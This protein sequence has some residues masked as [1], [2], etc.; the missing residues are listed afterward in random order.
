[1]TSNHN[2]KTTDSAIPMAHPTSV[3]T[4]NA[5]NN[6][7]PTQSPAI[8]SESPWALA[9]DSLLRRVRALHALWLM[10]LSDMTLEQVNYVERDRV[11][12][13]AFT[14]IHMIRMEDNALS[15]L[16]PGRRKRWDSE[17]WAARVKVTVD[18][19]GRENTVA[20]MMEERIGDY[21]EYLAF[22]HEIFTETEQTLD[23][24]DP[25]E[26]GEV[27]GGGVFPESLKNG[28]V[29]R[30]V[31]DERLLRADGYESWIYQ[32]GTRHL[33]ELEHARALVGLGG[34]TS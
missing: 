20:E 17:G 10:A 34:L 4:A 14:L 15:G 12:P 26:M 13:I 24:L 2:Y 11:L 21:D 6:W 19:A 1:M 18:A 5:A 25:D 22:V 27:I 29:H 32:H 30:M 16:I 3:E 31:R 23:N 9:L 8:T 28:Y 7:H 33:G